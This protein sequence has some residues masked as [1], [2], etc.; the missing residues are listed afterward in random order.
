MLWRAILAFLALPGMVAFAAPLWL[1]RHARAVVAAA[2]A[3]DQRP[4]P[5]IAQSDVHWRHRRAARVR[6]GGRDRVPPAGPR[7]RGA[8]GAAHVR[9]GLGRLPGP[10]AALA[11]AIEEELNAHL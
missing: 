5:L 8:L 1:A 3:R 9:C 6:P 10:G 2:Q 11:P 7:E 4:V